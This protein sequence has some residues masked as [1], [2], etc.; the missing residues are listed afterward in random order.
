P[1]RIA[2][3]VAVL[4]VDA[5][6]AAGDPGLETVELLQ[7]VAGAAESVDRRIERADIP[8]RRHPVEAV[9]PELELA[10]QRRRGS[11]VAVL[12]ADVEIATDQAVEPAGLPQERPEVGDIG[13]DVAS[14]AR[15]RHPD[16]AALAAADRE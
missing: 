13:V 15:R 14:L 11:V 3:G 16:G 8:P 7:R 9:G 10:V 4:Q 12:T 1:D 5:V 6:A 2:R